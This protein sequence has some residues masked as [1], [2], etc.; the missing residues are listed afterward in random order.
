MSSYELAN[1]MDT[2]LLDQ[3]LSEERY[4]PLK[5]YDIKIQLFYKYGKK[6]K[7]GYLKT[8]ALQKNGTPV[9]AQT[10]IVSAFNSITDEIDVKIIINKD[11]WDETSKDEKLSILDD[12]LN[13]IQIKE[14]KDGEPI[15]ISEDSDKVQLKLRKPDFYCEGFLDILNI[16]GKNYIP[17]KDAKR[18][19]D[20][21]N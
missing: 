4:E 8:P 11:L 9:Y 6:D 14:D 20:K 18:I 7:D 1:Q 3:L 5:S 19:A 21:I 10:K 17:W 15:M 12:Q 13:Y 2:D 16:H